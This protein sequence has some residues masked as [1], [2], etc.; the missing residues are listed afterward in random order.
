SLGRELATCRFFDTPSADSLRY[1]LQ[2]F[3]AE[4]CPLCD[5]GKHPRTK[6]FLVMEGKHKIRP[7][8]T[9]KCAVRTSLSLDD[10]T[11]AKTCGQNT[12][13]MRAGLLS[14]AAANEI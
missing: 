8:G 3:W 1:D 9:G 13:G 7:A 5:S 11:D 2:I 10:P 14:H 12:S 6:L 4:A